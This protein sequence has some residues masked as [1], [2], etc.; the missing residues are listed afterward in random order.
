MNIICDMQIPLADTL[1][2]GWGEL[3]QV[4]STEIN[5]TTVKNADALIVR[6]V[7]D[8]NAQLLSHSN[9]RFV[10]TVTAGTD[11]LD[12]EWLAS[13]QIAWA[14]A[15]GANAQAVVEYVL[16]C[17]ASLY[18]AGHLDESKK[19]AG[20]IGVGEI[21]HRVAELLARL[22][23]RVLLNDPPREL[24]EAEFIS[25][26]L[27]EF[28]QCDLICFHPS[29]VLSGDH[30][31]YHLIDRSFLAMLKP[32]AIVINASRG[33]VADTQALLEDNN[34]ILCTDVWE[35]EPNISFELLNKSFI[36]TPHIAG[37]S[38]PAKNQASYDVY[39][40]ACEYFN[41]PSLPMPNDVNPLT[42]IDLNDN[43]IDAA[44][45]YY[46]P[47]KQTNAM[48]K[49]FRNNSGVKDNFR[50]IRNQYTFRSGLSI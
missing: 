4:P 47:V 30:P 35:N 29:L 50:T 14:H 46:D 38:I 7:T 24:N 5:A 25:T 48:K 43:W 9:V 45:T 36:G 17:V 22:G 41:R 33:R 44:L 3:I 49:L 40:K 19:C 16:C 10:A 42:S 34:I 27:S 11:H 23:F 15:P 31:S 28:A 2:N 1:Y 32:N 8:I 37:Y 26:P 20:V 12:T 18:Q 6:S 21:G 39:L 13:K